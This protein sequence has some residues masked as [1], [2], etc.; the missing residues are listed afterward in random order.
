MS[1]LLSQALQAMNATGLTSNA[2]TQEN[3]Q[4]VTPEEPKAEEQLVAIEPEKT[5]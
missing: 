1:D 3:K 4:P 2:F 5:E